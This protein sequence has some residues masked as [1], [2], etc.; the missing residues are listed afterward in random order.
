[1]MRAGVS[2]LLNSLSEEYLT[3]STPGLAIAVFDV[4]QAML[5]ALE[6]HPKAYVAW[7][8]TATAFETHN[9]RST[10]AAGTALRAP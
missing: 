5:R 1:M 4:F 8:S 9:G 6:S 2:A 10:F 3:E 7:L